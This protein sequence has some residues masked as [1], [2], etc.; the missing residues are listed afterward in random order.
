MIAQIC[1]WVKH[2][3]SKQSYDS[4]KMNEHGLVRDMYSWLNIIMN[5]LNS[6]GLIKLGDVD[7]VRKN[8]SV[9]PHIKYENIITIFHN[10]KDLSW[11]MP[12]ASLWH[13]RGYARWVKKKT[14]HQAKA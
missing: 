4:F 14:L 10:M 13:L 11:M 1:L 9:L 6:I 3:L 2:S 5:E 7:I 8:I 12:L